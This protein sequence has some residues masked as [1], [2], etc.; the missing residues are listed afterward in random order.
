[1][2][3]KDY[4]LYLVCNTGDSTATF[5][6]ALSFV[7]REAISLA[8]VKREIH[9]KTMPLK[10]GHSGYS[11]Y[12]AIETL[13]R[14]WAP[15]I[16]KRVLLFIRTNP[17]VYLAG[18]VE[19]ILRSESAGAAPMSTASAMTEPTVAEGESVATPR[20]EASS[21]NGDSSDPFAFLGE[22][23]GVPVANTPTN[24]KKG[25]GIGGFFKKVAKSAN[26]Q[27]RQGMTNLAIRAD[28]GKSPDWFVAGMYGKDGQLLSMTDSQPLPLD[29]SKKLNGLRF[30]V[31]LAIPGTVGDDDTVTIKLWV[32]SGAAMLSHRHFLVGEISL[33][34]TQLRGALPNF[35]TFTLQS[36][37]IADAKLFV[38]AMSDAK[39][40][41][42]CGPGWSLADPD[43]NVGYRGNLYHL[44]LDQSYGLVFPPDPTG[45]W[46]V[47]TERSVESTVVLPIAAAFS[48]L[49]AQ[50]GRISLTHAESL[51]LRVHA[52]R[53]DSTIGEYVDS[54]F[55]ILSLAVSNQQEYH[56]AWAY[57]SASWQRPDSIFEV[58]LLQPARVPLIPQTEIRPTLTF[59]FFPKPTTEG[60]LPSLLHASGGKL[61]ACGFCLGCVS[62]QIAVSKTPVQ[63]N[64]M[65]NAEVWNCIIPLESL[66]ESQKA[67]AD[68]NAPVKVD[69]PVLAA[70]GQPMGTISLS[71]AL[72]MKQGPSM[73]KGFTSAKGGLLSL[74]G[75]TPLCDWT[76]PALDVVVPDYLT[77]SP[78]LLTR[79]QQQLATMGMFLTHGYIAQHVKD[80]RA[81][82]AKELEDRA[83]HYNG[84]LVTEA[85]AVPPNEDRSPKPFRPSSS[86]GERLLAGIPFNVHTASLSLT[87][88]NQG[89]SA[90]QV[91]HGGV[92]ANVTCGAPADRKSL[93]V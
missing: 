87:V 90:A 59:R 47:A 85:P 91:T 28:G 74:V 41:Q 55:S 62:L 18:G 1:M 19:A 86:R 54:T 32:R 93:L 44:P 26:T 56:S 75:L 84:A 10:E 49:A 64:V 76:Q 2:T 69:F 63:N 79:Q 23:E 17:N 52:A 37:A 73:P 20:S 5:Q 77:T 70:S 57:C 58:E 3:V 61:P 11:T 14:Q 46:L 22:E 7:C 12:S 16:G 88:Y 39:F 43:T 60:L 35:M 72:K 50:A 67:A 83:K 45:S 38:C 8:R 53:H 89:S 92:F 65:E 78:D 71:V 36:N 25:G 48:K 68:I 13:E 29:E 4:L 34:M 82:D 21:T 15:P 51:S 42:L 80:I 81:F 31:P 27:I 6:E 40:P 30:K 66:L 9:H 24:S 33:A